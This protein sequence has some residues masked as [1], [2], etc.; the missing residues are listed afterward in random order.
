MKTSALKAFQFSLLELFTATTCAGVITWAAMWGIESYRK[1]NDGPPTPWRSLWNGKA[2]KP[3]KVK[4][5]PVARPAKHDE[6]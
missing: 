2:I 4:P 3:P 6:E 1:A 5:L